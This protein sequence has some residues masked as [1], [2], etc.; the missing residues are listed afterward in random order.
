[1]H[2]CPPRGDHPP[3]TDECHRARDARACHTCMG[4]DLVP[5]LFNGIVAPR[6]V[7]QHQSPI[8]RVLEIMWW[9]ESASCTARADG[10]RRAG[11]L[12]S[13]YLRRNVNS[14]HVGQ[15]QVPGGRQGAQQHGG[16]PATTAVH[17]CQVTLI[18]VIEGKA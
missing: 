12:P 18:T 2:A 6:P 4:P 14:M 3:C 17:P 5:L 10:I 7:P 11:G 9:Y 15:A 8:H 16:R 13:W 1:M